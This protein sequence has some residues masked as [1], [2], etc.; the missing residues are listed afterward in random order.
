MPNTILWNL[1]LW[2]HQT[3]WE[4]C[5]WTEVSSL[6][7]KNQ[8]MFTKYSY[9]EGN[10]AGKIFLVRCHISHGS[11]LGRRKV[12]GILSIVLPCWKG[13]DS[14][15][16]VSCAPDS[17][18][19]WARA[20]CAWG[21]QGPCGQG[22]CSARAILSLDASPDLPPCPIRNPRQLS[23]YPL[24]IRWL[25]CAPCAPRG[26]E[27]RE[28]FCNGAAFTGPQADLLR[29]PAA[30]PHS[31]AGTMPSWQVDLRVGSQKVTC[32]HKRHLLKADAASQE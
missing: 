19:R 10:H 1:M 9:F 20:H 30:G 24:E 4:F 5:L 28:V 22:S 23:K 14:Q 3:L 25:L 32:V 26:W 2:Q 15:A 17:C 31:W 12:T 6:L 8:A 27:K 29:A 16:G 18:C 7:N 21:L 13:L 11:I